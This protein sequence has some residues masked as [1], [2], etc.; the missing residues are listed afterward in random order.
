[1]EQTEV[2]AHEV[3]EGSARDK[4]KGLYFYLGAC[5]QGKIDALHRKGLKSPTHTK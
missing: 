4:M 2:F 3:C 5:T 1:L